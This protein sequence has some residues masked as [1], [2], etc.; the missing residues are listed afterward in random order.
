MEDV[1]DPT[2][3][4]GEVEQPVEPPFTNVEPEPIVDEPVTDV[5]VDTNAT[6]FVDWPEANEDNK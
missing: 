1:E 6:D 4:P 5:S 3:D 2:T